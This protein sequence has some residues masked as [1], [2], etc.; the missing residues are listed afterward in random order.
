MVA[1][2]PAYGNRIL[3]VTDGNTGRGGGASFNTGAS[4]EKNVT[5]YDETI[6]LVHT[7]GSA[8]CLFSFDQANFRATFRSC[9]TNVGRGSSADFGYTADDNRAFYNYVDEKLY[10]FVINT[11]D[12]TVSRDPSFNMG[13]GFFDPDSSDCL[14]G[15]I[16]ANHWSIHG[17]ALSSDDQT[18]IASVGPQQDADVY[19]VIWN[20]SK[21]CRWLNVLTWQVSSGWNSGPNSGVPISWVA[22]VQATTPGGIHN[23]QIDRSGQYGVLAVHHSGLNHKM[24]WKIGTNVVD[25]SCKQ[26]T[27]HWACDYGVCFWNH[28]TNGNF[29]L[30]DRIIGGDLMTPDGN[31]GP[32]HVYAMGNE[33]HMSHANAEPGL[34]N[35]YL[36][37]WDNPSP[38]VSAAWENEL[39]GVSWDGSQKIV[40]FNKSWTSG[41][42]FW[43]T[44]RCSISRQGH[45]ALCGSDYQLYNLDR[46]FG[47]GLNQDT[48]DHTMTPAVKGNNSC[49]TD[50][51]LFELR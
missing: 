39:I 45:Y 51:L 16:A 8:L 10:R 48:C 26:C 40:R 41:L 3:R 47:N 32:T 46:G 29:G 14:G 4:A 13:Q 15:E 9:P 18:V 6:F 12:W 50:V 36:V 34:R 38:T 19:F 49:R 28:Q 24:F 27:S 37:S 33:E 11:T 43:S 30:V 25:G 2:D 42:S 1:I 20:A 22:G 23:A 31:T 35:P 7:A 17:H 44:A 21:G 5:S